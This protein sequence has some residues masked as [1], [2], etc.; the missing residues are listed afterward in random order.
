M[1]QLM[2]CVACDRCKLWGTLQFHAARVAIGVLVDRSGSDA[3]GEGGTSGDAALD[4]L[5]RLLHD[6]TC[7][8]IAERQRGG[9]STPC[10]RR[11]ASAM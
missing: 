10:V 8:T 9:G 7:R 3:A 4:G 11:V 6:H 1:G 5:Q 2:R